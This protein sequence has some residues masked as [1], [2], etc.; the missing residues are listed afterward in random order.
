MIYI[1][2]FMTFFSIIILLKNYKNKYSWF[3]SLMIVG[4]DVAFF[5]AILQVAKLGHYQQPITRIF[6][7]DYNVYLSLINFKM[8]LSGISRMM[9]A[10]MAIF[11]FAFAL[12]AYEFSAKTSTGNRKRNI[13][14]LAALALF[15]IFN[16]WYYDPK[17][18]YT[19]YYAVMYPQHEGFFSFGFIKETIQ[20]VDI[21]NYIMTLLYLLY[22]IYILW[23]YYVGTQILLK[24]MQAVSI[25]ASLMLFDVLY[26][27]VFVFS[28]FKKSYAMSADTL[29][30]IF[31]DVMGV[32]FYYFN[33]LP[34][35]M[36]VAL[37]T[38][39]FMLS[40]Y[41]ALD[42][43]DL[44][45]N[46]VMRKN[47]SHF[48]KN[49]RGVF[50]SFKNIF[51]MV[52]ILA[53]QAE[54]AYGTEK[55]LENIR[56]ISNISDVTMVNMSR[57]LDFTKRVNPRPSKHRVV[58]YIEEALRRVIISD[59]IKLIKEYKACEVYTYFDH[60]HLTE[61]FINL[62][63]NAVDALIFS[64]KE[65]AHIQIEINAE[66]EWV[67]VNITDNGCGINK[68]LL[69]KVFD[70]FYSTKSRQHNWGVG[71]SYVYRVMS[72]N[73]GFISVNSIEGEFTTFQ[74]LLPRVRRIDDFE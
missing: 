28:P 57:L 14:I 24:K 61:V 44:F 66:I 55:G 69:K 50:H 56:K 45:R 17:T 67:V 46:M 6:K 3:F 48:N 73:Y 25:A 38:I 41:K 42:T 34:V 26:A 1:M 35:I 13:I 30:W 47:I 49:L 65:D 59:N 12:F 9:N 71:L 8:P 16:I 51:F 32:P 15:L 10:G 20:A 58:D 64:K 60:Y 27:I 31:Q 4:L 62:L 7:Y 19:F 74:L 5:S 37:L 72:S 40:K 11:L 18:S 63:Q 29:R 68:K 2:L 22:P 36:L 33:I 43:T 53:E 21:A 23:R 39:F 52:K 70:P 54:E